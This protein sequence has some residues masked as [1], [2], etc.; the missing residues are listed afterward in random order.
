M[1]PA[2]MV[3]STWR[4]LVTAVNSIQ[5]NTCSHETSGEG[6]LDSPVECQGVG[7]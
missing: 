4:Y 2:L 5:H 7:V 1:P 6:L 3:G